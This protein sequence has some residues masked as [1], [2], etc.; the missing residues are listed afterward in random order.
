MLETRGQELKVLSCGPDG[1]CGT[2]DDIE[3]VVRTEDGILTG[4]GA[5]VDAIE[6]KLGAL[7]AF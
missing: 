7:F 1:E 2:G 6:K 3:A 5:N 4:D